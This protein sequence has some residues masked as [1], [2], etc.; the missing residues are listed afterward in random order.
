MEGLKSIA[1]QLETSVRH[2]CLDGDDL[3][4]LEKARE[5]ALSAL[6]APGPGGVAQ[7]ANLNQLVPVP[8]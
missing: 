4:P 7:W 1:A 5:Q 8:F 3:L 2:A 6:G